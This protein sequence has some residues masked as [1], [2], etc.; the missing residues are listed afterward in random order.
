[1]E[2]EDELRCRR[3]ASE[4]SPAL[5]EL[6]QLALK[7][8]RRRLDLA[9]ASG[10]CE[11]LLA[12]ARRLRRQ[13]DLPARAERAERPLW[14][15][16]RRGALRRAMAKLAGSVGSRAAMKRRQL[17]LC[18]PAVARALATWARLRCLR[19]LRARSVAAQ[20][21]ALL[22]ASL[23][24]WLR[25]MHSRR[26]LY[27]LCRCSLKAWRH[28]VRAAEEACMR[29]ERRGAMRRLLHG[30]QRAVRRARRRWRLALAA[31]KKAAASPLLLLRVTRRWA[32]AARARRARCRLAELLARRRANRARH[33][34]LRWLHEHCRQR[35]RLSGRGDLP[36]ARRRRLR[37]AWRALRVTARHGRR[38]RAA[39]YLLLALAARRRQCRREALPDAWAAW[40]S[41]AL[42]ARL[43]VAPPRSAVCRR[44]LEAAA[45]VARAWSAAATLSRRA[46]AQQAG[47]LP[48]SARAGMAH[49]RAWAGRRRAGRAEQERAAAFRAGAYA[50]GCF[51]SSSIL[52]ILLFYVCLSCC[53]WL[54]IQQI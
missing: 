37:A 12:E 32:S 46:A 41:A 50:Y 31:V 2:L 30:W 49:W 17:R 24:A 21:C 19:Q 47:A 8:E 25:R 39:A 13:A 34:A 7:G 9:A 43:A 15:A 10:A 38:L 35:A 3:L 14:E 48:R 27:Q 33:G 28:F 11:G 18:G 6:H 45:V 5:R 26:R 22:L 4:S 23:G 29:Y 51:C 52:Y 40:R 42:R 53:F 54:Y 36:A 1:M 44:R 20:W 16:R